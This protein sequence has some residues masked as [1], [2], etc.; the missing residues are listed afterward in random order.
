M[1]FIWFFFHSTSEEVR[2]NRCRKMPSLLAIQG[3]QWYYIPFPKSHFLGIFSPVS[4]AAISPWY[5]IFY[6]FCFILQPEKNVR[7]L[8][9]NSVGQKKTTTSLVSK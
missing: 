2:L 7:K 1:V 3:E 5:L 4:T 8:T 9:M 6:M